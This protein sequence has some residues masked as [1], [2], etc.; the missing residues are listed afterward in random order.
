MASIVGIC[1]VKNEEYFITWALMNV[2]EFCDNILIMD[3]LSDDL[4]G[5]IIRCIAEEHH[6]IDVIQEY[7]STS[8]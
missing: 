8:I 4:T 1:L 6:H 2:L 7:C 3:N 5:E